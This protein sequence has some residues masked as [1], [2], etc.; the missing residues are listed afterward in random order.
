MLASFISLAQ[1]ALRDGQAANS[2]QLCHPILPACH[3]RAAL[4]PPKVIYSTQTMKIFLASI[5]RVTTLEPERLFATVAAYDPDDEHSSELSI[6]IE[7]G[8]DAMLLT[9][10][11]IEAI[12]IDKAR[13]IMNETARS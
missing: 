4:A 10:S 8:S 5:K 1:Q 6:I 7:L 9:L 3:S 11:Q 12:A 13:K 2:L